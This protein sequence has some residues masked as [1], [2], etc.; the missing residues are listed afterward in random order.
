MRRNSLRGKEERGVPRVYGMPGRGDQH[1]K[2]EDSGIDTFCDTATCG[3]NETVANHCVGVSVWK[4]SLG[5][6]DASGSENTCEARFCGTNEKVVNRG[7]PSL[8]ITMSLDAKPRV[9][10][11]LAV[12]MKMW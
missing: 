2:H 9:R 11:H 12:Q 6:H 7:I 8:A 1:S 3:E 5:D 4:T 10:Q